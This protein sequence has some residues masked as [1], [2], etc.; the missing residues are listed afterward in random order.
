MCIRKII[1]LITITCLTPFIAFCQIE[2]MKDVVN[3]L[4]FFYKKNDLKYLTEAK[5]AVDNSFKTHT[6]SLDITK[7]VYK[8]VVYSSL[9]YIDSLNRLN[10]SD[11]LLF[12][13]RKLINS[14]LG[15]RK[16]YKFTLEMNYA[17]GCIANVYQRKAFDYYYKNNYG[18]AILNF[19]IAKAF[20]PAARQIDAYL[21]NIYYKLGDYTLAKNHYDTLLIADKPKLEYIQIAINIYKTLADTTKL[22][23][24]IKKGVDLYPHDKFLI[25][26][27]ANIYNN[28]RSYILLKPLLND[29]ME[30]APEDAK[31]LFIV[32]DC[33]DHLN[34]LDRAEPLYKKVI[35]LNNTDYMPV[36]NLGLLYFKKALI[37]KYNS[38]EYEANITNS[39]IY[40]EKAN[41]MDP[42]T[43][44]CL[45]ALQL[46]YLQTE[47]SNQLKKINTKLNQL[48]NY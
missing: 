23:Q 26:E 44:K 37:N 36:F 39:K 31:V 46:L 47:N 35:E 4:A 20:V 22:L 18:S 2:A 7:N 19:K 29:L 28:K 42:N 13:T 9:L 11:T 40:L 27:E 14:L 6:D 16:I 24:L 17:K 1:L 48:T 12:H 5:K 45:K 10:Q 34:E 3:N 38:H 32:A 30:L 8:A 25:F 33:C 43:E 15:N 21:A 41:E